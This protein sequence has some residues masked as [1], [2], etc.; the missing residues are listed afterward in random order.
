M[1]Q[2]MTMQEMQDRYPSEWL[3]ILDPKI[4]QATR[5]AQVRIELANPGQALKIGMYLNVSFSALTG[6]TLLDST[7]T[8]KYAAL[9]QNIEG[10]SDYRRTCI[11]AITPAHNT[12]GFD[13]VP[14]RLFYPLNERNANPNVPDPSVQ[15]NTHQF[16]NVADKNACPIAAP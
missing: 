1:D 8:E 4:D 9:F 2:A 3:L 13:R 10:I 15:L 12:Q 11:P 7:M 5:T 16:R 6:A 14:G